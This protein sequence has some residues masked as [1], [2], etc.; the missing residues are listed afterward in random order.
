MCIIPNYKCFQ[1]QLHSSIISNA[2]IDFI[3]WICPQNPLFYCFQ[4]PFSLPCM[5]TSRISTWFI[6]NY[7]KF[8]HFTKLPKC[9]DQQ[10]KFQIQFSSGNYFSKC[11]IFH[12]HIDTSSKVTPAKYA[13]AKTHIFG[14]RLIT[15]I[16]VLK[17]FLRPLPT[18]YF[19]H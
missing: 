5:Q 3:S 16:H 1:D 7:M 19:L 11:T 12:M 6:M 10:T 9:S 14:V 8:A 2:L 15:V 13:V 17:L 18:M 4:D